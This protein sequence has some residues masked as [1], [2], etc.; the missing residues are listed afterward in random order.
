[1]KWTEVACIFH[2]KWNG[3]PKSAANIGFV[4]LVAHTKSQYQEATGFFADFLCSLFRL[5]LIHTHTLAFM[6]HNVVRVKRSGRSLSSPHFYLLTHPSRTINDKSKNKCIKVKSTINDN[7]R[8]IYPSVCF[9]PPFHCP[10]FTSFSLLLW[11]TTEK[12]WKH[13]SSLLC[14]FYWL[15]DRQSF[16]GKYKYDDVKMATHKQTNKQTKQTSYTHSG[17]C[18][19]NC[20]GKKEKGKAKNKNCNHTMMWYS[21]YRNWPEI[22]YKCKLNCHW[23]LWVCIGLVCSH[24]LCDASLNANS[25]KFALEFRNAIHTIIAHTYANLE[26]TRS[27]RIFFL[28]SEHLWLIDT[29]ICIE[30]I[31]SAR[32]NKHLPFKYTQIHVYMM[33]WHFIFTAICHLLYFIAIYS[34]HVYNKF[35]R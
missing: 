17:K 28:Y 27:H 35:D 2:T 5:Q 7:T 4:R 29:T 11:S 30:F 33:K 19:K 34:C 32:P 16:V 9:S 18:N 20:E 24:T 21:C 31:N 25:N 15:Y 26:N 12:N 10:P 3:M 23:Q 22:A 14:T 13:T 8:S 6:W 1:M